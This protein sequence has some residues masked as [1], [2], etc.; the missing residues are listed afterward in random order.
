MVRPEELTAAAVRLAL[1]RVLDE[2]SFA[3]SARSVQAEIQ[4]MP[5]PEEVAARFETYVAHG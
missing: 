2:P 3:E 5:T 4:A 1:K